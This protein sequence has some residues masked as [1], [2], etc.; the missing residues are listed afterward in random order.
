VVG[1]IIREPWIS[2]ILSGRKTWE[3][4]GTNTRRRGRIALIKAG[5]STIVGTCDLV[6]VK[7]PLTLQ[8]MLRSTKKHRHPKGEL[9]ENGLPYKKTYAWILGDV[10]VL[11]EPVPYAHPRGAVTWVK[12]PDLGM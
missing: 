4:R 5:T 3:I 8:Q 7:G 6:D 1:L 12:L 11:K 2:E 10:H 9:A